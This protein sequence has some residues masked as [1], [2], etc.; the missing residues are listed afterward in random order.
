MVMPPFPLERTR[1][2]NEAPR[3]GLA[4]TSR[5][6]KAL[7]EDDGRVLERVGKDFR[8]ERDHFRGRYGLPCHSGTKLDGLG[9]R[10]SWI[11]T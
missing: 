1:R 9:Q 4:W 7:A 10:T 8:S 3:R 5:L 2:Y 6:P 11:S